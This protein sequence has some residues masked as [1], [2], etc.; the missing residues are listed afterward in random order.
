MTKLPLIGAIGAG[1]MGRGIVQ[2][3][4]TGEDIDKAA[5]YGFDFRIE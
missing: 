5:G 4:A 2:V 3:F 1:R